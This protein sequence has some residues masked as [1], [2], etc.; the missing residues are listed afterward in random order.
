MTER[1]VV[2]ARFNGPPRSGNGGY[3]AGLLAGRLRGTATVTLRRPIPLDVPL[4]VEAHPAR[5]DL[6]HDETL[7]ARAEPGELSLDVPPAVSP[8]DAAAA[9]QAAAAPEPNL[10][11]TCYGCGTAR[12]ED[13]LHALPAPVR[14][15]VT[16]ALVRV[17]REPVNGRGDTPAE[18][19]W[20][21]LDCPGGWTLS[22]LGLLPRDR[23]AALVRVT[24]ALPGRVRPGQTL[25]A[26]GWPLPSPAERPEAGTALFDEHGELIGLAHLVHAALPTSWLEG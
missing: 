4:T 9:Q 14:D 1:I 12:G 5:I 2:E 17:P 7:L 3:V 19:L 10:V 16:A 8:D 25:V 13:G 23:F 11:T 22:R 15:G 24:A 20:A 26:M 21:A 6:L 18:V